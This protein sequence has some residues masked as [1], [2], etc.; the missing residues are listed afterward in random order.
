MVPTIGK[1]KVAYWSTSNVKLVYSQMFND[2][3]MA[4]RFG[5]DMRK[6]GYLHTIME[7]QA[8]ND[9]SYTWKILKGGVSGYVGILT[10]FLKHRSIIFVATLLYSLARERRKK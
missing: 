7:L 1:Y 4:R 2:L 9:G 6:E 5:E 8:N 10:S 3:A